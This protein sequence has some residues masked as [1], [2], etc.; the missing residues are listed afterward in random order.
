MGKAKSKV[1]AM[2]VRG[3]LAPYAV[4]FESHLT[5]CGYAAKT[6]ATHLQVMS[7]VSGWL[8]AHQ[9]G[10]EDLSRERVEQYLD[11]R[12]RCGY[13][14]F[15]SRRGL[16]P[17]LQTLDSLGLLPGE[18][19]TAR[20][21]VLLGGFDR[22]LREERGL[23]SRTTQTYLWHA[24]RFLAG[25][26]RDGDLREL[27]PADVSAAVL[28][29]STVGSVGT[30]QL[31]V[32]AL[33]SLLRYCHVAGLIE[34][35][36]S[37]AALAVT[38]R[39]RSSLP[40]GVSPADARALLRSCD[41]RTALGRRD[42]AVILTLLRLGLRAGEVA[43]LRLEDLDWRAGQFT[44][45]GK[46]H[47]VDQLPIPSDVGAAIAGYLRRGRPA[48]SGREVFLTTRA[49]R[50]GL[51]PMGVSFIVRRACVRAGVRPFGAHRL[52][53]ALACDMVRAQVSLSEIGQ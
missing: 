11:W 5:E 15:C 52:R 30:V 48:T 29:E 40:K 6:R 35:D 28:Q 4:G 1:A 8:Q 43:A 16:R 2:R 7:H 45:H 9:L 24:R 33:R 18:A 49:P 17:L 47:R 34:T 50:T 31:F 44:V 22:Y 53:H 27:T 36:L 19:P 38:G 20:N 25:Y 32:T 14:A 23:V 46:G 39:R 41:R 37:G 26:G 42:Y 13:G 12:R 21:G 10:V 51:A 3:P